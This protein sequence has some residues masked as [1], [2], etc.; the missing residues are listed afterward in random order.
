VRA[1]R[2]WIVED[3]T[4]RS[5]Q[6]PGPEEAPCDPSPTR[7][8]SQLSDQFAFAFIVNKKHLSSCLCG[9]SLTPLQQ[10]IPRGRSRICL[11]ETSLHHNILANYDGK[12]RDPQLGL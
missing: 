7:L 9:E 12:G 3:Q 5:F 8:P 6:R 1:P 2:N 4:C 11:L 10:K